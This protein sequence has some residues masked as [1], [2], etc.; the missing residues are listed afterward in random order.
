MSVLS[1]SSPSLVVVT[2]CAL[3]ISSMHGLVLNSN[4]FSKSVA[5]RMVRVWLVGALG[6]YGL[7]LV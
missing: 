6:A 4:L 5:T 2:R 1:V 7:G 3:G